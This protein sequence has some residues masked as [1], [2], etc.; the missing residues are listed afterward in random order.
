[1]KRFWII[2]FLLFQACWF[3]AAFYTEQ[4]ALW[5]LV[6][7]ALHFWLSPSRRGDLKVLMLVSVGVFADSLH[8]NLGTFTV[9]HSL[10][11]LWLAL[12]WCMFILTLNHSLQWLIYKP[13]WLIALFG[14]VGGASSYIGGIK[15]GA[16]QSTL[17]IEWLAAIL[18]AAWALLFPLIVMLYRY[19]QPLKSPAASI[20]ADSSKQIMR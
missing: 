8:L 18:F 4:A 3:C 7:V 19:V 1:M 10:F 14:G 20:V 17:P 11:P 16:L 13:L 6:I 12:L 9:Q 15:A 2:N 5:M